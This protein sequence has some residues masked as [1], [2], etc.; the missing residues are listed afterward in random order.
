ME[1]IDYELFRVNLRYARIWAEL[2]ASDLS[3]MANLKQVKSVFDIEEGRGKPNLDEVIKIC[4]VLNQ[5]IHD[6]VCKKLTVRI[7]FVNPD[8]I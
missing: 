3:K 7:E 6:M 1:K 4:K 2:S 5:T 8:S